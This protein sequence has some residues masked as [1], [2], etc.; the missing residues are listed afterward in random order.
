[1]LKAYILAFV[2]P[3]G[4]DLNFATNPD[5]EECSL[6]PCLVIYRLAGSLPAPNL[7]CTSLRV[8]DTESLVALM[9]WFPGSLRGILGRYYKRN[10]TSPGYRGLEVAKPGAVSAGRSIGMLRL[11]LRP[12]MR[13]ACMPN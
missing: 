2:S 3:R 5:H 7:Y 9:F 4:D 8:L 10:I 13:F 12:R 1:M 6:F 11:Q